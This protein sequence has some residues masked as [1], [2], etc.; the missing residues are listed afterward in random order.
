MFNNLTHLEITF[1]I[2]PNMA[3]LKLD[4]LVCSLN[5]FPKLQ[6][7]II[8]E[9][10]ISSF[11]L[12]FFGFAYIYKSNCV[13]HCQVDIVDYYLCKI[14]PEW[15]DPKIVPECLLTRLTTCSLKNY[16]RIKS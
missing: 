6:I 3:F 15:V 2:A 9:V 8:N 4:R 12:F 14:V 11:V 13:Y 7:L 10:L 16:S 1:D 5:K